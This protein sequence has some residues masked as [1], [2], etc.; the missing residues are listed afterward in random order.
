MKLEYVDD[1]LL[2]TRIKRS[3]AHVRTKLSSEK[4]V[5]TNLFVFEYVACSEIEVAPVRRRSWNFCLK[6]TVVLTDETFIVTQRMIFR[7]DE[8]VLYRVEETEKK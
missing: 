4:V 6:A 5:A 2:L 1:P 7:I 8:W 3:Y